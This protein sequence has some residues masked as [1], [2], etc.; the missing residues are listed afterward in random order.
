MRAE[1]KSTV[2][3]LSFSTAPANLDTSSHFSA[4][5]QM[6]SYNSGSP[7][8]QRFMDPFVSWEVAQ[9]ENKWAGRNSTRWRSEEDDRLFRGA[10]TER[11]PV[12]RA[13]HFT[14]MKDLPTPSGG[15]GPCLWR[16]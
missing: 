6:Y 14:R 3:A 9:K 15:V 5:L 1:L 12:K 4:D 11:D 13:A 10:E 16:G 8:P 2:P 7:D